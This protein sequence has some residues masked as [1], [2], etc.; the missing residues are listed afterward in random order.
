MEFI[1]WK[2][3][4][5]KVLYYY[6]FLSIMLGSELLADF[7]KLDLTIYTGQSEVLDFGDII[8]RVAITNPEVADA[9]VTSSSQLLID[10]K[11]EGITS[12]I[13]WNERGNYTKYK[14]I[15]H[16]EPSVDQVM[17]RV[18]FVEINKSALKE[19]GSDFIIKNIKGDIRELGI[20]DERFDIG[21]FGGKVSEPSD[22]LLLGNTVD[23]F[24]AVPTQNFSTIFKAL[25]ENNLVSILAAPNL[26]TTSGSEANFLAG[27]EFPVPIVSGSMGMQ[28]VTIQFKEYGVKL[29]FVPTILDSGMIQIKTEAEVSNLDFENGVVLSGFQI[30]SLKTRKA[31]ATVELKENKYLVIGGLLSNE[32]TKTIS[33]IP[34]L[35]HIPILGLLFSSRKF[36]NNESELLIVLSP[37]IVHSVT[38]EEV[39]ELKI[40][41]K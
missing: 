40:D 2:I 16:K 3:R 39:P 11:S 7:Q 12:L 4:R 34:I 6:L 21:S 25:H 13:I 22:P 17:L 19:L 36:I 33:R 28:Q 14:L 5:G 10:G 41:K 9:T 38:K 26:S 30:P 29:N 32:I 20:T 37:H 15:V 31:S 35:G 24:F 27:G 23:F 8:K 18:R 1:H